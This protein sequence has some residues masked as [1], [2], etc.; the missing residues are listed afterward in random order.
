MRLWKSYI[1]RMSN[2]KAAAGLDVSSD[3]GI[4]TGT[5][6]KISLQYQET[7]QF[8]MHLGLMCFVKACIGNNRV[9]LTDELQD[10]NHGFFV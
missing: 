7:F 9:T 5:D 8:R 10:C 3:T 1:V 2:L 4:H 6:T